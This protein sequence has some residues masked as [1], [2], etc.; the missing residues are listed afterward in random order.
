MHPAMGAKLPSER[1][2]QMGSQHSSH[3]YDEETRSALEQAF[4]DAWAALKARNPSRDWIKDGQLS[5]DL[6]EKLMALADKGITKPDELCKRA[7][8]SLPRRHSV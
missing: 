4:S 5:S 2:L 3:F 7:L 1:R 6:T 8:K